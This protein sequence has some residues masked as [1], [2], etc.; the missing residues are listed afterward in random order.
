MNP[1][2][3]TTPQPG[4]Q[5]PSQPTAEPQAPAPVNFPFTTPETVAPQGIPQPTQQLPPASQP[6]MQ[7]PQTP[8]PKKSYKKF[9]ILLVVLLIAIGLGVTAYFIIRG[10]VEN[11]KEAEAATISKDLPYQYAKPLLNVSESDQVQFP[12]DYDLRQLDS[13]KKNQDYSDAIKVFTDSSF[14]HPANVN[15]Y[16]EKSLF[17]RLTNGTKDSAI[18]I[19][20]SA[21]DLS[22][23]QTY[24]TQK[25][26]VTVSPSGTWGPGSEYYYCSLS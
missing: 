9:F 16:P 11:G 23:Q 5:T 14:T 1:A 8:K 21:S 2:T 26:P 17:T 15:V 6:V 4:D 7:Q 22:A 12:V 24:S 19:K 18:R 13:Y 25:D 3:D 10:A 20:P